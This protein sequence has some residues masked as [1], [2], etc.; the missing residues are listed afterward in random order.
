MRKGEDREMSE[1]KKETI[2]V[3]GTSGRIGYAIAKRF[4]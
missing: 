1:G 3:T 4:G 2:L